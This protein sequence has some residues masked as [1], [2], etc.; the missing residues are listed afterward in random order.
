MSEAG[1][2]GAPGA[3]LA[4]LASLARSRPRSATWAQFELPPISVS[5]PEPPSR[6][7][8]ADN[9][10]ESQ[11]AASVGD[12]H[13]HS[14]SKQHYANRRLRALGRLS[15]ESSSAFDR[16]SGRRFS[17]GGLSLSLV[18][19]LGSGLLGVGVGGA[20]EELRAA[21]EEARRSRG[22]G[23]EPEMGQPPA[24]ES[25]LSVRRGSAGR[26]GRSPS[27][28]PLQTIIDAPAEAPEEGSKKGGKLGVEGG[29]APSASA[30]GEAEH[31]FAVFGYASA[32][33]CRNGECLADEPAGWARGDGDDGAVSA[34]C[35]YP[36]RALDPS[37]RKASLS[38]ASAAQEHSVPR[39][40]EARVRFHSFCVSRQTGQRRYGH[41]LTVHLFAPQPP[42][43]RTARTAGGGHA[44]SAST[45]GMV[46]PFVR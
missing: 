34:F 22:S 44:R 4:P 18:S 40:R 45:G 3:E 26:G 5:P 9:A 38:R 16:I 28:A 24:H 30:V 46:S 17:T 41:A 31:A 19:G 23:D 1:L 43:L 2:V 27:P 10:L 20:G 21:I 39:A 14:P 15:E 8:S 11:A 12:E 25:L 36:L 6:A 35:L 33:T 42:V 7:H 32:D 13:S 29:S 37:P